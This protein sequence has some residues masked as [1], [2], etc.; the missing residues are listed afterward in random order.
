MTRKPTPKQPAQ[1]PAKGLKVDLWPI[2]RLKPY[3]RNPRVIDADTKERMKAIL[4]EISAAAGEVVLFIDELHT[5]VGAGAAEGAADAAN[6]L[7]PALARGSQDP[8]S[9]AGCLVSS[10]SSSAM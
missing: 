4:K 7:K 1:P 2:A 6:L 3:P 9:I 5:I 10:P 8:P